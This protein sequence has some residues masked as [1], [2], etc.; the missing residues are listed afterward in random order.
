MGKLLDEIEEL[1]SECFLYE[2]HESNWWNLFDIDFEQS[3]ELKHIHEAIEKYAIGFCDG[4]KVLLRPNSKNYAIMF[5][6]DGEKFWF[7]VEKWCF[8]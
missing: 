2:N 8:E 7:H 6:K 3:L 5:E 1:N 4:S